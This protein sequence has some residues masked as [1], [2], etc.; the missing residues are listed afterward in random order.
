MAKFNWRRLEI[1]DR[2]RRARA[3]GYRLPAA[4]MPAKRRKHGKRQFQVANRLR[5]DMTECPDCRCPVRVDRV[6]SHVL[7]VH[8]RVWQPAKA[9]AEAP[10]AQPKAARPRKAATRRTQPQPKLTRTPKAPKPH[11]Y[12]LTLSP[13]IFD[14]LAYAAEHLDLATPALIREALVKQLEFLD[15]PVGDTEEDQPTARVRVRRREE[16]TKRGRRKNVP[17]KKKR[18]ATSKKRVQTPKKP[19]RA[20]R[21]I[22]A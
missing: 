19:L 7:R 3:R 22:K 4:R 13:D 10:L 5:S 2:D 9:L 18:P 15:L 12:T 17:P 21:R 16:S 20:A 1:E 11:V 8:G 14:A 6:A